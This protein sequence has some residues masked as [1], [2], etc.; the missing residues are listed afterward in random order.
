MVYEG[1]VHVDLDREVG[2]SLLWVACM[3][4][5]I[6]F[7]GS[8]SSWWIRAS[9]ST[10]SLFQI[11]AIAGHSRIR[12][13]VVAGVFGP[14]IG[15]FVVVQ[16]F[17]PVAVH[18]VPWGSA[19]FS[20]SS[21]KRIVAEEGLFVRFHACCIIWSICFGF[22]RANRPRVGLCFSSPHSVI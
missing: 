3:S 8:V 17:W 4:C 13:R 12:W 10:S 20:I 22:L 18:V 19:W 2:C 9:M 21:K 16:L 5:S 7:V 1:R 11:S 14:H 15:Q 6:G